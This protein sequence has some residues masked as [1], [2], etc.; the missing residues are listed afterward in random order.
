[1]STTRVKRPDGTFFDA[2][3]GYVLQDG[4]GYERAF[5]FM[6]AAGQ[7]TKLTD[8]QV[9]DYVR[10]EMRPKDTSRLS[11][12]Q[13]RRAFVALRTEAKGG[14]SE[15]VLTASDAFVEGAFKAL[16][17]DFNERH[18]VQPS[19]IEQTPEGIMRDAAATTMVDGIAITDEFA[20]AHGYDSA[21][22]LVRG[23]TIREAA[24]DVQCADMRD[25]WRPAD[26]PKTAAIRDAEDPWQAFREGLQFQYG[27]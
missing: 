12:A 24:Y 27:A 23:E 13:L 14:D 18:I 11:A 22:A 26:A 25:A 7:P 4:E 20:K 10:A 1:M 16:T 15:M 5:K 17:A 21:A 6:D 8:E 3:P 19:I 2:S 9:L